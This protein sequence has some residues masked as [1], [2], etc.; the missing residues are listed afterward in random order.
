MPN[1]RCL[2]SSLHRLGGASRVFYVALVISAAVYIYTPP[3][4]AR[5]KLIGERPT[6]EILTPEPSN[7]EK[8]LPVF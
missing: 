4:V 3:P 7:L 2:K 5:E 1:K 8:R 6:G